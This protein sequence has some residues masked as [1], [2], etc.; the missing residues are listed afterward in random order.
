MSQ[1]LLESLEPRLYVMQ[2]TLAGWD[3]P[4]RGYPNDP[5]RPRLVSVLCSVSS[6]QKLQ[7]LQ[8]LSPFSASF[9]HNVV[10]VQ[11][12]CRRP[13]CPSRIS[14]MR[15]SLFLW[16]NAEVCCCQQYCHPTRP[17]TLTRPEMATALLWSLPRDGE[18]Y[19]PTTHC[20]LTFA[21]VILLHGQISQMMQK[22]IVGVSIS[23]G[24]R[25]HLAQIKSCFPDASTAPAARNFDPHFE[26]SLA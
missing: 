26:L 10:R 6:F 16:S 1:A 15:S 25:V 20:L 19:L 18:S 5:N 17:K 2:A 14:R 22:D 4:N 7:S 3:A 21:E 12:K 9:H 8:S 13:T 24:C 23:L 11:E